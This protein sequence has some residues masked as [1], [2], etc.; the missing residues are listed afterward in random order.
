MSPTDSTDTY[1][2]VDPRW[3]IGGF[4]NWNDI[5]D[6]YNIPHERRRLGM[7]CG[8]S[9][10]TTSG[11]TYYSLIN[12]PKNSITTS[13]DWEIFN[14]GEAYEYN[15]RFL[16]H[17]TDSHVIWDADSEAM[18]VDNDLDVLVFENQTTDE[19][20]VDLHNNI[21]ALEIEILEIGVIYYHTYTELK[22][23]QSLSKL[24]PGRKYGITDYKTK[25]IIPN[26][27]EVFTGPTEVLIVEAE[28]P[29]MIGKYASSESYPQD[30][31]RYDFESDYVENWSE[32]RT[33]KITYRKDT[34][35]NMSTY[36]D[37][38]Q[39]VFKRWRLSSNKT[40]NAGT[41][42][43]RND[44]ILNG[45]KLYRSFQDDNV[46]HA[47]NDAE[48]WLEFE[49]N[50]LMWTSN[51]GSLGN[52][53]GLNTGD[54]ALTIAGNYNTF[55]D[56]THS[57]NINLTKSDLPYN[58]IVFNDDATSSILINSKNCH[59]GSKFLNN[60]T[61]YEM[62]NTSSKNI[63]NSAFAP[64]FN[65]NLLGN[66]YYSKF[67]S[68][69]QE[70]HLYN[71]NSTT[72]GNSCNNN[73]IKSMQQNTL[74][75]F[76]GNRATY[77]MVGNYSNGAVDNNFFINN[78]HGNIIGTSFQNNTLYDCS[79]NKFDNFIHN[80]NLAKFSHNVVG[81]S[82]DN[83][84][85]SGR[86][87]GKENNVISAGFARNN[88]T[89][90]FTYNTFQYWTT[91]NTFARTESNLFKFECADNTFTGQIQNNEFG[92]IRNNTI[93]SMG[94]N[95]MNSVIEN[96]VIGNTFN[97]NNL[98]RE[99]RNNTIGNNFVS[100]HLKQD[101]FS[102]TVGDNF[103][104]N[105]GTHDI[106]TCTMLDN[107][108]NNNIKTRLFGKDFTPATYVYDSYSK[109]IIENSGTVLRLTYWDNLNVLQNVDPL[110]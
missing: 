40:Y 32:H 84:I 5:K 1:G 95:I 82:F 56:Y 45:G 91:D 37:F 20:I 105:S 28:T 99:F 52:F 59:F 93:G 38:R 10:K 46:G 54:M 33:G 70:N 16:L 98:P 21:A 58:N 2:V 79:Y 109:D 97:N 94:Y 48:W 106:T 22:T 26:T 68:N 66:I 42:Y 80:N 36:Y 4:S 83:N 63:F 88:I 67:G 60:G 64:E 81:T 13:I 50:M 96:N 49:N 41:T 61:I 17:Q 76:R 9:G 75:L 87:W 29:I 101:F 74:G 39:V 78:V 107:F 47:L 72:F 18:M 65:N 85:A 69:F 55:V 7:V 110:T 6:I 104:N 73:V 12:N 102:N 43:S 27:N 77:S 62:E 100:N 92:K 30:D 14:S 23:L 15:E 11:I 34:E 44:F 19:H 86:T 31:L 25:H 53:A 108:Q 51:V 3:G 35:K 24:V 8:V 103:K 71:I 90:A 89:H 57:S